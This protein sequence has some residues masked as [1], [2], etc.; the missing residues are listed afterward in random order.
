MLRFISICAFLSL[1]LPLTAAAAEQ[2]TAAPASIE[3]LTVA[4]N[5]LAAAFETQQ[6]Q[7]SGKESLEKL[8][9]AIA[10]L[11]F[12]SR[13]IESLERDISSMKS[14][15]N[16]IEEAQKTWS[17]RILSLEEKQKESAGGTSDEL[18]RMIEEAK[19]QLIV[20]KERQS[21]LG[22]EIVQMENRNYDLQRELNAI[23][24]FVERHLTF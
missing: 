3:Q 16:N 9:L 7:A 6:R 5:R 2:K 17:E 20:F 22:D 18:G 13:R 4:V 10:Y 21:R 11:S 1:L 12:R 24:T 19:T 14:M 8:N 15:R 23:E